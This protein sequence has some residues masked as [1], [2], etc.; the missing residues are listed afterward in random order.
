LKPKLFTGMGNLMQGFQAKNVVK[1]HVKY[2]IT[3]LN[4]PLHTASLKA[5]AKEK[6]LL[7]ISH[8]GQLGKDIER[9]HLRAD[10]PLETVGA[11]PMAVG[12]GIGKIGNTIAGD[13]SNAL[14]AD[15]EPIPLGEGNFKYMRRDATSVIDNTLGFGK[16]VLT[17]HPIR[18]AGNVVKGGFDLVDLTLVDP[19]LDGGSAVFGHAYEKRG[20]SRVLSQAI[21]TRAQMR[22]AARSE[23]PFS[24]N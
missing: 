13:I 5:S 2:Y 10:G 20:G 14:G 21:D 1:I 18:A 4:M 23:T 17:L 6:R 16:N 8:T 3:C 12:A 19:L 22:K 11:V 24:Q 9:Y 15:V 7:A